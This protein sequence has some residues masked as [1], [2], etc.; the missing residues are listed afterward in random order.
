[1]FTVTYETEQNC[2]GFIDIY[3]GS[4]FINYMV[5]PCPTLNGFE[6]LI[7]I[8]YS[9]IW[10]LNPEFTLT[11]GR[12]CDL[13][14][15]E[16][17]VGERSESVPASSR[18]RN[19]P[20]WCQVRIIQVLSLQ[21]CYKHVKHKIQ[22]FRTFLLTSASYWYLLSGFEMI[23]INGLLSPPPNLSFDLSVMVCYMYHTVPV[24]TPS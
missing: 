5:T 4:F 22:R 3:G 1:M 7:F 18:T 21:P 20:S 16:G 10:I 15:D 11:Q 2:F 17:F 9:Q 24:Q 8:H 14:V 12:C 19:N 13:S 23:W 6:I